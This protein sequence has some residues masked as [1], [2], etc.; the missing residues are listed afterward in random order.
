MRG[1]LTVDEGGGAGIVLQGDDI[2]VGHQE[3]FQL[4]LKLE[5]RTCLLISIFQD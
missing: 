3:V 5:D 1:G 4:I 2:P